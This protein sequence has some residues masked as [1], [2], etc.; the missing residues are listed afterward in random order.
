MRAKNLHFINHCVFALSL[1]VC[2]VVSACSSA[3][4]PTTQVTPTVGVPAFTARLQPLLEAKMQQLHIPGAIIF[5]DDPGQGSWTTTLGT[6][7]LAAR[8]PMNVNS[9]MRIGSITK[10]FTATVILQLVDEG[11]LRLDDPVAKYLPQVPNGTNTTIRELLNMTSGL[12]DYST[13]QDF[14]QADPGKVWDTKDLIAIAFRHRPYFAPGHGL[15]YTNTNYILLGML[16]EQITGMPVE[17][18]F[19][20]RIFAP[21]GMDGSSLPPHPSSV[22]PDPHPHGYSWRKRWGERV[23]RST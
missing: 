22:I 2:L 1:F 10:T 21:L 16:I 3:R 23:L 6:S 12:F 17:K 4:A 19:Q 9:Y 11:K 20:Q 8:V 13:D 18:A 14:Q 15:H 5:V 7:D